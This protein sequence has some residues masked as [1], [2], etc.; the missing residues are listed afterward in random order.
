MLS[1]SELAA[2]GS[3]MGFYSRENIPPI[4]EVHESLGDLPVYL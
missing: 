4:P 3:R 2:I 1:S